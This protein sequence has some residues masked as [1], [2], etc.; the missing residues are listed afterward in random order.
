MPAHQV[1]RVL[2]AAQEDM[3]LG[4]DEI[5][6]HSSCFRQSPWKYWGISD[7][8]EHVEALLLAHTFS[9]GAAFSDRP[10][11]HPTAFGGFSFRLRDTQFIAG[12]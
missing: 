5:S 8:V 1:A 7:N 9:A 2:Y 11:A 3:R 4:I 10:P 12:S 6:T